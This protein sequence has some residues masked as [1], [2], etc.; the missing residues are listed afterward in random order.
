MPQIS[1]EPPG[2]AANM[3]AEKMIADESCQAAQPGGSTKLC[4]YDKDVQPDV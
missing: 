1:V 3:I 4:I 2:W